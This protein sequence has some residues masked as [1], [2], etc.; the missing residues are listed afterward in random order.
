MNRILF[1]LI[2]LSI[3]CK[4]TTL[5]TYNSDNWKLGD[6]LHY[7]ASFIEID[8]V[9][10]SITKAEIST[11]KADL[12]VNYLGETNTLTWKI[13]IGKRKN[14][15][16]LTDLE[17]AIG[18]TIEY[19]EE[20]KIIYKTNKF[21]QYQEILNWVEIEKYNDS[22]WVLLLNKAGGISLENKEKIGLLKEVFNNRPAIETKTTKDIMALHSI[23]GRPISKSSIELKEN[24]AGI[25]NQ[26]L[27]ANTKLEILN[28]Y[29]DNLIVRLTMELDSN[30]VQNQVNEWT[31]QFIPHNES[32]KM[33]T[34]D[35]C[36]VDYNKLTNWPNH[37]EY[38]RIVT[39]GDRMKHIGVS[40]I[41][42][43]K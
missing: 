20:R 27:L 10:D 16:K 36:L 22:L 32:L 28:Y 19:K 24:T 34:V 30:Q 31:D 18:D 29:T 40:L 23:Y 33:K 38:W 21:G 3:G 1:T 37:V 13:F 42:E 5:E 7:K 6:T 11:Y 25:N 39:V 15:A 26:A 41:Q 2:I 14:D 9:G 8:K 12:I 17:R 35:T 4:Q 43:N